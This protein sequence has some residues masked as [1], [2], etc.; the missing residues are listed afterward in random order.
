[1]VIDTKNKILVI[2]EKEQY[3]LND[4]EYKFLVAIC[5]EEIT[6][7]EKIQKYMFKSTQ[8]K[9]R[10]KMIRVKSRLLK[11]IKDLKIQTYLNGYKLKTEILFT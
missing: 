5:N 8:Y 10:L 1:M 3:I 6:P 7:F 9:D 4:L 2:N 11:Y